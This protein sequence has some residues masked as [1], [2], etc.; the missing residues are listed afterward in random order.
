KGG[1]IQPGQ[2][3]VILPVSGVTHTVIKGDTLKSI[4]KKYKADE[5][6]ITQY[7]LLEDGAKLAVG[8]SIII[9]DGEIPAPVVRSSKT[10]SSWR[11]SAGGPLIAGYYM[12][13]IIGGVKSQGLHG[14]NGVDLASPRGTPVMAS[15]AGTVILSRTNGWNAGYGNYIVIQHNNGTQ[16]LYAHLSKNLIS[17]GQSVGQGQMIGEVGSTGKSTGNH[18]HFEVRGAANPF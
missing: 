7:N 14:Y 18:V 2:T 4:A 12:R 10:T 11:S 17:S 15:A 16:T 9:P 5:N 13:P 1:I 3:L 8:D 6:E